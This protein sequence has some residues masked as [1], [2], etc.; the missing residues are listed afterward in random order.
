MTDPIDPEL[1]DVNEIKGKKP[2]LY[3][4]ERSLVR[5]RLA[6]VPIEDTET[7]VTYQELAELTGLDVQHEKRQVVLTKVLR[8]FESRGELF[9][10]I[11]GVGYKR[12]TDDEK[13]KW[14]QSKQASARRANDRAL[15]VALRVDGEL[16]EEQAV[17]RDTLASQ[18]AVVSKVLGPK[19]R[20]R[21]EKAVREVQGK[22]PSAKV[23]RLFDRKK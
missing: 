23:L 6:A 14:S 16:S 4:V 12:A 17:Q 21:V 3:E 20:R 11:L 13:L 1:V 5:D 8:E 22:L 9:V 15:G 7:V 19:G 10:A 18:A 2:S